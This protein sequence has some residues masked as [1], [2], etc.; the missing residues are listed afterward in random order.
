[1]NDVKYYSPPFEN[2]VR[3]LRRPGDFK[4]VSAAMNSPGSTVGQT[5]LDEQKHMRNG[6]GRID[7]TKLKFQI[8][9][10]RDPREIRLLQFSETHYQ[11]LFC[12]KKFTSFPINK[13]DSSIQFLSPI[14][15][16]KYAFSSMYSIVLFRIN[17]MMSM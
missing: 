9:A 5:I 2:L 8:N 6:L 16:I 11:F 14:F 4:A 13:A 15:F 7:V 17:E 12:L 1:M 10:V 3:C